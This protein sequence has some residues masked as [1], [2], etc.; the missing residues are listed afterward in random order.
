MFAQRPVAIIDIGSNSVRLV[1]YSGATRIPSVIFNEKILAGLGREVGVTGA[2]GAAA[3]ARALAALERFTS[4]SAMGVVRVR[5]SPPP[6]CASLERCRLPRPVRELGFGILSGDEE[7]RGRPGGSRPSPMPTAS[8]AISAAAA[9]AGRS[10]GRPVGAAPRCPWRASRRPAEKGFVPP[11][12]SPS[13]R[14]AGFR[15][16]PKGGPLYGG[17][18]TGALGDGAGQHPLPITQQHFMA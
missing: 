18:G 2:I 12:R 17:G 3:E 7:G 1:V 8:S 11:G 15:A 10:V 4:W 9:S 14:G 13:G 6:R 16:R 5:V